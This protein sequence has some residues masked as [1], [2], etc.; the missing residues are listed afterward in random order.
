MSFKFNKLTV[1]HVEDPANLKK[2]PKHPAGRQ[3]GIINERLFIM[4]EKEKSRPGPFELLGNYDSNKS[5]A[6]LFS[7]AEYRHLVNLLLYLS[8]GRD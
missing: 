7:D 5:E 8:L 1:N 4:M 2:Q 6:E 3:G